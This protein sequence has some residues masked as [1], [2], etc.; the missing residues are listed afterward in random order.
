MRW[1]LRVCS[2]GSLE[3][4]GD[5]TE[6]SG[7]RSGVVAERER[8]GESGGTNDASSRV[9]RSDARLRER[10]GGDLR[11]IRLVNESRVG[12]KIEIA[13]KRLAICYGHLTMARI[14]NDYGTPARGR[15][16]TV[17]GAV[18]HTLVV[19]VQYWSIMTIAHTIFTCRN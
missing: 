11:I 4:S 2:W 9:T 3:R 16:A 12:L 18:L 13:S 6:R 5:T 1:R 8:S 10:G 14:M 17:P 7:E 19:P 15:G